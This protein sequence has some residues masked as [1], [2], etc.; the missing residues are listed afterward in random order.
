MRTH[1]QAKT[2][3]NKTNTPTLIERVFTQETER[4]NIHNTWHMITARIHR[5]A[6]H[7]GESAYKADGS[8]NLPH[9]ERYGIEER[10]G[11][12]LCSKKPSTQ[13]FKNF[14][15]LFRWLERCHFHRFIC[16]FVPRLPT[17][18]RSPQSNGI[19]LWIKVLLCVLRDGVVHGV[20]WDRECQRS[21][22]HRP[23]AKTHTHKTHKIINVFRT[24][25]DKK[26]KPHRATGSPLFPRSTL[27]FSPTWR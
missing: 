11:V 9:G 22:I 24:A 1:Y 6:T 23:I 17:P 19:V 13:H 27:T 16:F 5:H 3:Q 15:N 20:A 25:D 4:L 10:D 7:A 21:G 2:L 12:T 26:K 14:L 8:S 18:T